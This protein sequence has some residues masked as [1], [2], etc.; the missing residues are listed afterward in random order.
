MSKSNQ[1]RIQNPARHLKCSKSFIFYYYYY[2]IIIIIILQSDPFYMFESVLTTPYK[3]WQLMRLS[4]NYLRKKG[5][6]CVWCVSVLV[7]VCMCVRVGV[8][9]ISRYTGECRTQSNI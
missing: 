8:L 1:R 6:V 4:H 2:I 7:F 5:G 3:I 9:Y